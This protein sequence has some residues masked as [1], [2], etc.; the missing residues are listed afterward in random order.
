M[1]LYWLLQLD[2]CQAGNSFAITRLSVGSRCPSTS[3][4][5]HFAITALQ[6]SA[7]CF[8]CH[9]K[10]LDK[11]RS[12]SETASRA[13]F[14]LRVHI[15]TNILCRTQTVTAVPCR[16]IEPRRQVSMTSDEADHCG[17]PAAGVPV[18][19]HPNYSSWLLAPSPLPL[20]DS[21]H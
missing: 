6:S 7:N 21:S 1:Y 8:I 12:T 16:L 15:A 10:H 4:S 18:S 3:R 11:R 5:F 14:R 9:W 13:L 19:S 20:L 17:W 2:T